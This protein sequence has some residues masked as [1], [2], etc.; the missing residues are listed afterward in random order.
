VRLG[1][2]GQGKDL[3]ISSRNPAWYGW[4]WQDTV[5]LGMVRRGRAGQGRDL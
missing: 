3:L 1:E 4:V 2:V 5:W